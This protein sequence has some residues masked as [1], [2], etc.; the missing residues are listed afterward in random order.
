M[1]EIIDSK[2]ELQKTPQQQSN[3][4]IVTLIIIKKILI[5]LGIVALLTMITVG[6]T[7]FIIIGQAPELDA[8]K[9]ILAQSP[10]IYDMNGDLVTV[11]LSAENRRSA[12]IDEIPQILKDAV[13]CLEDIHFYQHPGIDFKRILGAIIFNIT[14]GYGSQGAST[15]TQQ[16][17]KNLYLSNEKTLTRKIQEL[18]LAIKLDNKYSK[19]KVLETYLN[20]IYYSDSRYGVLEAAD[21]YF[22]KE[23]SELTLEDAALLAAI[24][25]RPNYFNPFKNPEAAETRRNTVINLMETNG[26]ITHEAAEV[27]KN[28]PIEQQL[29][30]SQR[31]VYPYPSFLDQV[32]NELESIEE[33]DSSDIYTKGLKVY[34]T[35]DQN[36]QQ[37]VELVMQSGAGIKFP[38]DKLQAG[39][40]VMDTKTGRVLAIGGSREPIE[41]VRTW[42]WATNPRRSPGSTIKP[43]LDYGP[44]VDEFKWSTYHQLVDEPHTF[45]NGTPVHNYDQKYRGSISI[46]KAMETSRN[47]PAIKAFQEVGIEKAKAFGELL[48]IELDNIEEAY[49]IGGFKTG[50]SSLQMAGAYGAFGNNGV[51]SAP[52]TISKVEF[53]NEKV[54]ELT[55]KAVVA[56]NDYTAFIITDILRT[57]IEGSEGTGRLAAI[58]GIQIAGK[59][60]SSNFTES[61][62]KQY[63]IRNGIKDSWFVGYSTYLTTSV[64]TGYENNS[65]G[66][67]NTSPGSNELLISRLLFKEIMEYGHK[68]IDAADFKQPNSVVRIGIHRSDGLL[69]TKYTFSRNI[70][71]EYFVKGTEPTEKSKL[72]FKKRPIKKE[73]PDN[74]EISDNNENPDNNEMPTDNE[75]LDNNA[76]PNDNESPDNKA[77]PDNNKNEG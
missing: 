2:Q 8:D 51:Y 69:P 42:N 60:G 72:F 53:P 17:V 3:K 35:L 30:K 22:S 7:V 52:H 13:I 31:K 63:K 40:T 1:P 55:P 62:K 36:L 67:I 37:H 44:A 20:A 68:Q 45:S 66:Y 54:I 23:L 65:D 27:S 76:I 47:I 61:E 41:S 24:P 15:I 74:S 48:G 26:K 50:V 5:I 39:I 12:D 71:Y 46:R 64:W 56:M 19:D 73:E 29:Q 34:T 4:K 28:I 33:I 9:L 6:I 25:Q 21:Y 18:Y 57:V 77:M 11:L 70:I 43:I 38:D 58:P 32:L 59:T 49:S 14:D 16:V 75:S 10:Q